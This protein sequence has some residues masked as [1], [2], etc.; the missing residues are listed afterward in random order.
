MTAN[1][2]PG[3]LSLSKGFDKLQPE[4]CSVMNYE[5]VNNTANRH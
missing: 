3:A 4:R 5:N 1:F 2:L